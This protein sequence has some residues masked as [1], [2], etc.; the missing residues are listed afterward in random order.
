ML[1]AGDCEIPDG[2]L[3][4]CTSTGLLVLIDGGKRRVF[5]PDAYAAFGSPAVHRNESGTCEALFA[6][7][8]GEPMPKPA[9]E[10]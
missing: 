7:P 4:R 9:G 5:S 10:P 1:A 3:V 2:T 6:C 8:L